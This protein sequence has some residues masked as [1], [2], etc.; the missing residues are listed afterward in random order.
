MEKFNGTLT[1][2]DFAFDGRT[3]FDNYLLS[4]PDGRYTV[5]FK[6]FRKTRSLPQNSYFHGVVLPQIHLVLKELGWTQDDVKDALK[7]KYAYEIDEKTGLKRLLHTAEMDTKR[8]SEF[9][10]DACR[11]AAENLGLYIPAP[12]ERENEN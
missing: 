2:K 3:F 11:W 8:M 12:E 5:V 10:E 1:G 4:L 9:T 6:K 7:D